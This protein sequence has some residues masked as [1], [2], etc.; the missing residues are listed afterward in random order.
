MSTIKNMRVLRPSGLVHGC[1]IAALMISQIILMGLLSMKEA[2]QST[3]LLI[4]LPVVTIW[5]HKY[6]NCVFSKIILMEPE[7]VLVYASG[8]TIYRAN[9]T[10][11]PCTLYL[12]HCCYHCVYPGSHDER[13]IGE[14]EGTELRFENVH[15]NHVCSPC[16]QGRRQQ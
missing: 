1:T 3:P 10:V 11:V 2:A 14:S 4:T 5:F 12:A 13:H 6:C 8:Q 7:F 15:S 16:L 9:I